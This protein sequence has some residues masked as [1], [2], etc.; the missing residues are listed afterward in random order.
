MRN[1]RISNFINVAKYK[2]YL[3]IK[4]DLTCIKIKKITKMNV[5]RL[6][7]FDAAPRVD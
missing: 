5:S 1:H 7:R 6:S 3:L 2:K 4:N